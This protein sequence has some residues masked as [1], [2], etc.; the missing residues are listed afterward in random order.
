MATLEA[1]LVKWIVSCTL[2]AIVAV[3]TIVTAML[4]FLGS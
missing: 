2:G 3:A 4:R 1:R